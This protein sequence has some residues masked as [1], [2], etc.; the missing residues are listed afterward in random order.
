QHCFFRRPRLFLI[1]HRYPP[2]RPARGR[3]RGPDPVPHPEGSVSGWS[4]RVWHRLEAD[5]SAWR[6]KSLRL[7]WRYAT[8]RLYV[9]RGAYVDALR[10]RDGGRTVFDS[11]RPRDAGRIG[12]TGWVPSAD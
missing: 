9:G 11:E 12:A 3:G 2:A 5:L 1:R 7:R 4:G 6:G 10:V 8:D